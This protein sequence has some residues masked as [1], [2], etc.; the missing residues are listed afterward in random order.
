MTFSIMAKN[1]QTSESFQRSDMEKKLNEFLTKK[2]SKIDSISKTNQRKYIKTI[3]RNTVDNIER[4]LSLKIPTELRNSIFE[5]IKNENW[6]EI[7]EFRISRD[8]VRLA[9]KC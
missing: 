9:L 6:H 4:W 3:S 8:G 2:F 5:H 1:H 7:L